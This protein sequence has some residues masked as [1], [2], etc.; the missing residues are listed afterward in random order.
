MPKE[1][2]FNAFDMSCVV[3]QSP[4]LWGHPRDRALGYNTLDYWV[5]LAR[6]AE[7]GLFDAVFIADVL[8][9]YDVYKGG[10]ETAL[11]RAV[12]VPVNDPMMVVSAMALVTEHVGFGITCGISYEHPY[13]FARRMSTLD[14]LTKGRIGWNIVTGYLN[15][16]A[17]GMGETAQVEHDTRYDMAEDYMQVVYKLWEGSWQ[18]GA[19]LRD[20]VTRR[21]ADASRIHRIEHDG[22]FYRSRAVHL[23]EPSP[24]RTPV[25]YQA[26]SSGRGRKFAAD[27]AECVFINGPTQ[28][29]IGNTV[30][31]LRKASMDSGRDPAELLV[32]TM[33]TIITG[34]TA[35][36]ARDKL[37]DYRRYVDEDGALTLMS[38]WTGIDFSTLDPDAPLQFQKTDAQISAL[39]AFTT[40]A[41]PGRVWTAREIARHA[42]IGGRGPMIVGSAVEVADSLEDWVAKTGVDGF[43]LAYALAHETFTDIAELVVPI[44]QERGLFKPAYA[45]GTLREKLYGPGRERLR[46]DHPAARYRPRV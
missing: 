28:T 27:H 22:P 34:R 1:I 6:I 35:K 14:H 42:C 33:M 7:R 3:H 31:A 18:D 13:P 21:F 43:N 45:P 9:I 26:G 23:C 36:E 17:L 19:V 38:G 8:G 44:L 25:L 10:P 4:G 30:K 46:G 2:R 29:V 40:N 5:D 37:E 20:R 11:E 12:Q 16:A 41:D 24:Q 39:Q 32:F 15:S